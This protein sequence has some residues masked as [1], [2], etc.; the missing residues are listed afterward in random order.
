MKCKTLMGLDCSALTDVLDL[1]CKCSIGVGGGQM[2]RDLL[3]AQV[4]GCDQRR[5]KYENALKTVQQQT[6][7]TL[8]ALRSRLG[9]GEKPLSQ[10]DLAERLGIPAS[11]VSKLEA[12]TLRMGGPLV[13]RL[14][15]LITE[16]GIAMPPRR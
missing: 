8:R 12:G 5:V 3:L 13:E 2:D 1:Q 14:S 10:R 16:S 15:K 11:T 9:Q 4:V 7:A 6:P